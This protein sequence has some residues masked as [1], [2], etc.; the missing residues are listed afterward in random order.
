LFNN[1]YGTYT[2]QEQSKAREV[3]D[4][5]TNCYVQI[6]SA[7]GLCISPKLNPCGIIGTSPGTAIFPKT[8]VTKEV[9]K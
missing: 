3:F 8:I 4:E 1:S 7:K 6:L 5:V 2:Q 9:T